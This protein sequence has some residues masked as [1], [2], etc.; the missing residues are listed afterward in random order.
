MNPSLFSRVETSSKR[1][2]APTLQVVRPF[3]TESQYVG[4]P[5]DGVIVDTFHLGS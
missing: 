1:W 5:F 4:V 2:I 3:D